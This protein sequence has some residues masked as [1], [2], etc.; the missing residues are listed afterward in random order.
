MDAGWVRSELERFVEGDFDVSFVDVRTLERYAQPAMASEEWL[1]RNSADYHVPD[2][3]WAIVIAR[4]YALCLT[5]REIGKGRLA[6]TGRELDYHEDLESILDTL[7]GEMKKH[8]VDF[9][10]K[11]F[12]DKHGYDDRKIAH[13][14][15]LGF[16][17]KHN[18]LIHEAYGSA[19]NI[20]YLLTDIELDAPAPKVRS[21]EC[22][23][24]TK[25]IR[26][27]PNGALVEGR[28][29]DTSKC[30]SA[31]N[32][33]K[34][35]LDSDQM[36]LISDWVYGCDICQW[37]CPYNDK[38]K[39]DGNLNLDLKSMMMESKSTFKKNHLTRAYG[40]LGASRLKRNAMVILARQ[41]GI[42]A[43]DDYFETI[44]RIPML[45]DQ[46]EI[47]KTWSLK[48]VK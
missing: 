17:G 40:Y 11:L 25:C 46:Y 48:S 13:A 24:C 26:G 18:L 35:P 45:K 44:Q 7:A 21:S 20:G 4:P 28:P 8:Y 16:W 6:S 19:F 31:L 33:K 15:G 14:S 43:L 29:L 1:S 36:M 2:A 3:K 38:V 42:E 34:G 12:I 39:V 37:C 41:Y 23:S 5:K 27:C 22:G 32:Q 47:L 30:R 9:N 10:H